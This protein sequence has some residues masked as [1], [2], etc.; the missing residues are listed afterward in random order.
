M[1]KKLLI[2]LTLILCNAFTIVYIYE[3]HLK[4]NIKKEIYKELLEI[5]ENKNRFFDI[6]KQD[7]DVE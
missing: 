2:I 6:K 5:E 4:P 7:G 3:F 1:I